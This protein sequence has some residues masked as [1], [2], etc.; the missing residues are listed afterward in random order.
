MSLIKKTGGGEE[1]CFL[2]FQILSNHS[3]LDVFLWGHEYGKSVKFSNV[4]GIEV[5]GKYY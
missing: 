3:M 1:N 2:T 4:G 5:H